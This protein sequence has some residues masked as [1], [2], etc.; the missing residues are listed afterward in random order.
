MDKVRAQICECDRMYQEAYKTTPEKSE[1]NVCKMLL[2]LGYSVTQD[3]LPYL[4]INQCN[5]WDLG[6]R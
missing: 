6:S 2:D 4:C 5:R 1:A 3:S